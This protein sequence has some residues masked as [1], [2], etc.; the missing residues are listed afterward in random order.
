MASTSTCGVTDDPVDHALG[1]PE[2][3]ALVASRCASGV[4]GAWRITGVCKAARDG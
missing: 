4:V 2:I 1:L 3:W